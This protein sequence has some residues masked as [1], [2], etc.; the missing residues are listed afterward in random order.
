[1]PLLEPL[2]VAEFLEE[3][4]V[5]AVMQAE[6]R[7]LHL[8]VSPVDLDVAIQAD[9]QLLA[10][11]VSNLLENAFKYSRAGGHISL[12]ARVTK[13][14]VLLEVADECGGFPAGKAETLLRPFNRG[15]TDG[16][17]LGLGL[18]IALS[19]T[20]ANLGELKFRDVPG[21]GCVFTI[22]LPRQ[23]PPRGS[24]FQVLPDGNH[25][26]FDAPG[27]RPVGGAH[28]RHAKAQ[29]S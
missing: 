18:S 15:A 16:S 23:P 25:G 17:G 22:D 11:A 26:P 27:G 9:R 20:Q 4:Q 6:G 13:D 1:M 7:G 8:T 10:S 28:S 12:V 3:V 29:T 5:S 24:R 19:A 14:R 2:I 21:T